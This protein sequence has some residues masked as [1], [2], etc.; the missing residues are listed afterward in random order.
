MGEDEEM[1]YATDGGSRDARARAQFKVQ[2]MGEW[3][4]ENN[5]L[6][7]RSNE[8]YGGFLAST[9]SGYKANDGKR[10]GRM[11]KPVYR[12]VF[13]G[14]IHELIQRNINVLTRR[15]INITNT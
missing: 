5:R 15:L 12:K 4:A 10:T 3:T 9:K 8:D 1:V 13:E 7:P 2:K 6:L 14:F 11:A